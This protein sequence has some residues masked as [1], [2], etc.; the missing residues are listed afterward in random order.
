VLDFRHTD[1]SNQ[2]NGYADTSGYS[3]VNSWDQVREAGPLAAAVRA[4]AG[5]GDH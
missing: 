3:P 5:P 1:G 4:P 2:A